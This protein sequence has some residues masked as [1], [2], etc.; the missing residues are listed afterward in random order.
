MI[1]LNPSGL[2]VGAA[3]SGGASSKHPI[4]LVIE[5]EIKRPEHFAVF[6]ADTGDEHEWTY[7]DVERMEAR[8]RSAGIP[9]F[10]GAT[11]RGETLPEA[12]LSATRGERTRIDNPP[13]WTESPGGTR[14]QLSQKCTQIWKTRVI[15]RMQ[16]AWL[17]SLG[18]PKRIVTWIGFGA[19]E[20]ARA[21][22]AAARNDV[23]WQQLDFPA[24]RLGKPRAAQRADLV[25]LGRTVP[26]FSMCKKCP[27]KTPARW[28]QTPEHER[29]EAY[30]LDEAIRHGLRGCA[31]ED[32]AYLSDRLIPVEQLV[33]RGDPQPSLPGMTSGCDEGMCFV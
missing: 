19:D 22:K 24:I 26:R 15:R 23:Q 2:P 10:R 3:Y 14:G 31:V 11:H 21:M 18:L 13:Y 32:P 8:C 25:R 28:M 5:G 12:V 6:F 30:E 29:R 17:E 20:Q 4:E 16:S 1:D 9:F 33:K 27:F 7:E